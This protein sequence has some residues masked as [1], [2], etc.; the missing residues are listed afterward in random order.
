[1][2][3]GMTTAKIAVSVPRDI[4]QR[5]RR[6]VRHGRAGS[7]SAYVAAALVQKATL[8]ELDELLAQMLAESGGPLTA[9]EV[10]AADDALS[11]SARIG[12][13]RKRKKRAK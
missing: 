4:L 7:M 6:A 10:R 13:R 12:N 5:A 8:D 11:G 3:V 9:T 1:M 2:I